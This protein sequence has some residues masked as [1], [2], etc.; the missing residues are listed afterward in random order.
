MYFHSAKMPFHLLILYEPIVQKRDPKI[1][2]PLVCGFFI[3]NKVMLMWQC[4]PARAFVLARGNIR[5]HS[6]L[7]LVGTGDS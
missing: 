1:I 4:E 7:C 2:I 6:D 3:M 5:V